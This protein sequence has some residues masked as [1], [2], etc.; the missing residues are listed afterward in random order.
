MMTG[1]KAFHRSVEGK[2]FHRRLGNFIAT[3]ITRTKTNKSEDLFTTLMSKQ[4]HLKGLNSAKQHLFVELEYY[5]SLDEQV[6]IE[7]II[8]EYALPLFR[9]IE[10]KIVCDDDL[11]EDDMN[12]LFD[13]T[14]HTVI[15]ACLAE[16]LKR[17]CTAEKNSPEVAK[18]SKLWNS[19]IDK[20]SKDDKDKENEDFYS[21][22]VAEFV[23]KF[24][25]LSGMESEK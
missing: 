23:P 9:D 4:S 10:G 12:F 7:E 13:I 15:I 18:V 21:Q 24:K 11:N 5:H 2:R 16:K 22:F 20:L 14:D 3:R 25:K 1:I 19:I 8:T 17:G 6:E